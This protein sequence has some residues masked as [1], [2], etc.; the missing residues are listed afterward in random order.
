MGGSWFGFDTLN[1]EL[2][3]Y[4]AKILPADTQLDAHLSTAMNE[5]FDDPDEPPF[6]V[7]AI[8]GE[9]EYRLGIVYQHWA[10]DSVSIQLLLGELFARLHDPSNVR[11]GPVR[12][13]DTGYW[14]MFCARSGSWKSEQNALA[15]ARRYL[16]YRRVRKFDGTGLDDPRVRFMR[17]PTK[18]GLIDRVRTYARAQGAKV[19]DVLLAA[20]LQ[21]CAAHVPLQYRSKR[22]EL[23]VGSIVDLRRHAQVDLSNTFGL[24]LG[25]AGIIASMTD[26][27][28]WDRLLRCVAAQNRQHKRDGV[29]QS[30]LAWMMTARIAGHWVKPEKLLHFYRK[31][32]PLV[33]GLSNVDLSNCWAGKYAPHI[34]REYLRVS[35][36]GPLAPLVLAATTL[37]SQFHLGITYRHSLINDDLAQR[38]VNSM[39]SRLHACAELAP[40]P[41]AT[42]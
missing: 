41:A 5:P 31:E 25:F 21:A 16:R 36:T 24:F 12:L 38:V 6:R 23:A 20:Q 14:L 26:I 30:S 7:F 29:A 27:R 9:G 10:A 35:P 18:V 22:T 11:P 42:V 17:A 40:T 3:H 28:D 15:L 19:H 4:P 1:G 34:V 8:P 37:G 33:G 39:L 32:M 2:K 13:A